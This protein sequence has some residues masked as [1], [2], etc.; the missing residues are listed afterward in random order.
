MAFCTVLSGEFGVGGNCCSFFR[1]AFR[2]SSRHLLIA[3]VHMTESKNNFIKKN[4]NNS[5]F[6]TP[7]YICIK[8]KIKGQMRNWLHPAPTKYSRRSAFGPGGPAA[9]SPLMLSPYTHTLSLLVCLAC[10]RKREGKYSNWRGESNHQTQSIPIPIDSQI[11]A[12]A[13]VRGKLVKFSLP[14]IIIIF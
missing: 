2:S 11:N 14:V 9:S 12:C 6:I 8:C 4:T 1:T 7:K 3:A 10:P 5:N 13:S